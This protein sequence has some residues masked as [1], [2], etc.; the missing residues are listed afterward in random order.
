MKKLL[1]LVFVFALGLFMTSCNQE[2]INAI[3]DD[4]TEAVQLS[5]ARTS[6]TSDTVTKQK[7]KGKLTEIATADL[8]A[9][10][11]SYIKANYAGAEVQFAGK[12]ATGQIVVGL[13]LADGTHKGLLFNADGTFNKALEKY[14]KGAKL[15]N[16]DAAS[17]PAAITAYITKNYAGYT[18]KHAGKNDAGEYFV[19]I[20]QDTGA[21]KVLQFD[22]NGVFKQ[23]MAPP[24][25]P[26]KGNKGGR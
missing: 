1:L 5:A 21:P 16:V 4:L 17:L 10:V 6:A 25:H 20:K 15:T 14:G 19:A 12:D 26:G 9:S 11:S 24:P 8:P 2:S 13:K 22:A 3:A 18:I 7:C 23:E